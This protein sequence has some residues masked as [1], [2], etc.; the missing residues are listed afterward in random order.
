M[1]KKGSVKLSPKIIHLKILGVSFRH[2]QKRENKRENK[3]VQNH[4]KNRSIPKPLYQMRDETFKR[5]IQLSSHQLSPFQPFI[6]LANFKNIIKLQF[7][8]AKKQVYNE[9]GSTKLGHLSL[10][11][12]M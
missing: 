8:N 7:G 12:N 10:G 9:I 5:H 3:L 4:R 1:V 2:T 6:N 11:S